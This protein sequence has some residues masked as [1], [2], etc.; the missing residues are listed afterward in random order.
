MKIK[1]Y[2]K[3]H[4]LDLLKDVDN[5][6]RQFTAEEHAYV[7]ENEFS[8]IFRN[9]ELLLYWY[10]SRN[11]EK[12][13]SL[14]FLIRYINDNKLNSIL[15][16]GAGHCVLEYL[17]SCAVPPKTRIIA[18]DFDAY[19]IKKAKFLFPSITPVVFDFF[20]DNIVGLLD[21]A[22]GVSIW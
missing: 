21:V 11:P 14:A 8:D 6:G 10:L 17:L 2:T 1:L 20:N 4:K 22:G 5:N 9:K 18:A 7:I 19:M 3:S 15:S 16:L 13:N 12:L